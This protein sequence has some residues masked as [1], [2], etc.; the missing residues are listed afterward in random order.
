MTVILAAIL[1]AIL[2]VSLSPLAKWLYEKTTSYRWRWRWW[3]RNRRAQNPQHV[4]QLRR[5][6][7]RRDDLAQLW[8]QIDKRIDEKIQEYE[9]E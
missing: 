4:A 6:A 1:G 2:A 7:E 8:R 3:V 9:D 5:A